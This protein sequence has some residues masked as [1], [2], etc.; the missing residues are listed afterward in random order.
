MHKRTLHAT[1]SSCSFVK[2]GLSSNT[3]GLLI[4]SWCPPVIKS[5]PFGSGLGINILVPSF[6]SHLHRCSSKSV[7]VGSSAEHSADHSTDAGVGLDLLGGLLAF[8][9]EAGL[10]TLQARSGCSHCL[11]VG[12]VVGSI[13]TFCQVNNDNAVV[14]VGR[15]S[16]WCAS[17]GGREGR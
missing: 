1:V 13:G 10:V 4:Q 3:W 2:F 11:A 5:S 16:I 12:T 6:L 8:A 9:S 7:I 17:V 15:G 14:N